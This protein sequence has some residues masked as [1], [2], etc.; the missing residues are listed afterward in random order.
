MNYIKF[1]QIKYNS[2]QL[3]E[4]SQNFVKFHKIL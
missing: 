4:T 1:E 2:N 3:Y